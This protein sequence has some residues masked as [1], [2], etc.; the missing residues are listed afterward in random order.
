MEHNYQ[1]GKSKKIA[2]ARTILN[3][4]ILLL[5]EATSTLEFGHTEAERVVQEDLDR[6]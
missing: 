1:V 5:D 2:I 6:P 4:G 3:P